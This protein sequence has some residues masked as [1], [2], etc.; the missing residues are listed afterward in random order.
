MAPRILVVGNEPATVHSVN[1]V[2]AGNFY[3]TE[4]VAFGAPAV[5]RI[6]RNPVPD[7]VLME[8]GNCHSECL[9][10]LQRFLQ[11]RPDLKVIV[12]SRAGD[13][14]QVVEAIRIGAHDYINVPFLEVEL[15]QLL[16]RHVSTEWDADSHAKETVED[17]GGGHLFI[18]ASPLMKKVRL[19]AELLANIDVPVLI[20]GESGT[21]KEVTSHLIHKLSAR[22]DRRLLKVNCAALPGELLESELFG[23]ESGAFTGAMRTKAGKFELCDKGTILL[24]EVAE[25]SAKLQAKLLHVLQDKQFFRLGG[26]ATIE[27]DVRILA[28][29]NVDI[30]QAMAERRFREDLYYLLSAF[31]IFLPPLRE[32]QEEI[33]VLLYHF[34]QRI[35]TQYS[36]VPLPFSTRLMDACLHYAWPGNLQE[37]QNFVKRYLVM[38]DEGLALSDLQAHR[39]R[40]LVTVDT[41]PASALQPAPPAPDSVL[42]PQERARDLKFLV[43]NLKDETEIEAIT[44]ALEETSWNR[45]RA[46]RLLHISYRGLLYKVRQH[47]ITRVSSQETPVYQRDAN[48][49]GVAHPEEVAVGAAEAQPSS[50][51]KTQLSNHLDD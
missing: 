9:Q 5:A 30:Q 20:L 49:S 10:T 21:G 50:S 25:M 42:T 12:L 45:K 51:D 37:L 34:M 44:K 1:S 8:L 48:T 24:D 36:R 13:S 41:V 29:T 6:Y 27:V 38:A 46:A 16:K 28:A 7:V 2:L 33:P 39:R 17:V 47:G 18:S 32:R 26:E 3:N 4:A 14:R 35:A 43:R 19:Q 23:H 31:T 15:L 11:L 40:K 22:S